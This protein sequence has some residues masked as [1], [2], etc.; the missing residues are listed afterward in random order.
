MERDALVAAAAWS[1][2]YVEW[3]AQ[4]SLARCAW[5]P[6]T[7]VKLA[8]YICSKHSSFGRAGAAFVGGSANGVGV[9]GVWKRK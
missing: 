4:G 1:S 7:L 6:E 9:L 2:A 5:R 3:D 8:F